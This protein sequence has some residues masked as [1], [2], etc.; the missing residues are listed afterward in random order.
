VITIHKI[1][2]F[3]LPFVVAVAVLGWART[4]S[5]GGVADTVTGSPSR[6]RNRLGLDSERALGF[7]FA[8]DDVSAHTNTK[9]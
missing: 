1:G 8:T 6:L 4:S 7:A 5:S 2:L 3:F 9:L